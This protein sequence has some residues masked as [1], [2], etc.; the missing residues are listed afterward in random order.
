MAMKH[1][2]YLFNYFCW[3]LIF[4]YAFLKFKIDLYVITITYKTFINFI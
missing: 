2:I 1:I 3:I 4:N